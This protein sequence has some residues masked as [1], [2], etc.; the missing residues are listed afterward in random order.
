MLF[1]CFIWIVV[2]L[3][4]IKIFNKLS[5]GRCYAETVMSGKVVVVTGA[6]GGIGFE[7]AL[8][9]ARRGAKVIIAC[10]NIQK[11]EKA[12][13]KIISKTRNK[14][15]RFIHLDLTSLASI[16]K[17][18][19]KLKESEVKLDVLIN[20]AGAICTSRDRTKDGI[21]KDLQINYF[22]PFLLTILLL[23]MLRHAA[24]SRIIVVSSSWHRFG[25]TEDINSGK[26]NYIQSY[27]NSKLCNILFSK[28]LAR[29][30]EGTG[31]DVNSLN[32]GQ[33]NTALYRSSNILEKIRSLMLYAFFKSPAD[34]A[35][36]SVYLAVSHECDQVSGKYFEDCREAKPSYK[37][38]DKMAA[39]KLWSISQDLVKLTQE[40]TNQC[41]GDTQS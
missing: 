25:T 5:T 38:E 34:G 11:G 6:S 22:A 36:T 27:A 3:I 23:P 15:V 8:E 19:E 17:F 21:L 20:N 18:V 1:L 10:R 39:A 24:P 29:K 28:E 9:L 7:T 40:E 31:I 30:L 33:V 32:P 13:R 14:R 26:H 16:R 2:L 37:A 12:V 35:Q 4:S 41:F